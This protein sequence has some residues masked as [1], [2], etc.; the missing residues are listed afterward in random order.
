MGKKWITDLAMAVLLLLLMAYSLVGEVLHEWMGI[1][2]LALFVLHH[3]WNRAW[4]KSIGRGRPSPYRAVQTVLNLLLFAAVLGMIFSGL[5]LSQHILD[6][7][8]LRRGETIARTLHLPLAYWGFLLMSLH[9]GLHWSGIMNTVRR[10][11]HMQDVPRHRVLL[12]R[13][14]AAV[15]VGYGLY[16]FIH[17]GFADYLLLRT[18]FVFFALDQTAARFVLDH[19]AVMGLFVCAAHY[20]EVGLRRFSGRK[21]AT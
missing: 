10:C 1:A 19:L 3:I 20:G 13:L 6:F 16:V 14:L 2:M 7:L 5:I 12:L 11:L 15:L 18:H 9:L 17:Y 21:K 4:Y 8:P